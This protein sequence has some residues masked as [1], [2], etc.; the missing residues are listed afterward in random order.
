MTTY[1]TAY[2]RDDTPVEVAAEW[3]YS[4][5]TPGTLSDAR[6]WELV[7]LSMPAGIHLD[8]T[9]HIERQLVAPDFIP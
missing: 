7:H 4:C 3:Q 5:G 6:G 8:E 9:R 1:Q 2:L